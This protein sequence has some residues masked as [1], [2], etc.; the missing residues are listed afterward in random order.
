MTVIDGRFGSARCDHIQAPLDG[1]HAQLGVSRVLQVEVEHDLAA[2]RTVRHS[3]A[4][5][6]ASAGDQ[7]CTYCR[8]RRG[9]GVALVL[10][11]LGKN[12]SLCV[13]V[14]EVVRRHTARCPHSK[15]ESRQMTMW[16]GEAHEELA[17]VAEMAVG[18]SGDSRTAERSVR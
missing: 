18:F 16:L 12:N 17:C 15:L 5:A 3:D 1:G 6:Q 14:W 4:E 11:D 8:E 9:I 10:P 13:F 7:S 2:A